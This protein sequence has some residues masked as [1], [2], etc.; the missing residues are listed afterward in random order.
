VTARQLVAGL[1]KFDVLYF[2]AVKASAESEVFCEMVW[3]KAK[4]RRAQLRAS[5]HA[6]AMSAQRRLSSTS[7]SSI[8]SSMDGTATVSAGAQQPAG[9][10][11]AGSAGGTGGGRA[12][13]RDGEAELALDY[14][15]FCAVM[16]LHPLVSRF[17]SLDEIFLARGRSKS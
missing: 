2:G 1:R 15:M 8:P 14:D 6:R 9:A 3:E 13:D 5:E 7:L 17:F 16:Q 11:A 4:Q 10:S 12:D